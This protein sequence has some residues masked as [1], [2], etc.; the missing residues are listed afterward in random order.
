MMVAVAVIAVSIPASVGSI[1]MLKRAH[2]YAFWA[3]MYAKGEARE[4]GQLA[5]V[6]ASIRRWTN[7]DIARQR[8]LRAGLGA[9]QMS[10]FLEDPSDLVRE[11][12]AHRRMADHYGEMRQRFEA[13]SWRPWVHVSHD[14]LPP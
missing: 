10:L 11:A 13:A 9:E 3:N 8:S 12:V 1:R 2:Y 14:P 6:E 4:L 7:P 5:R